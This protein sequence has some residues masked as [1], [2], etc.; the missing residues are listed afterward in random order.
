MFANGFAYP[1]LSD[2]TTLIFHIKRNIMKEPEVLVIGTKSFW[3]RWR[4]LSHIYSHSE[5]E[6]IDFDK[7]VIK[8]CLADGWTLEPWKGSK[9]EV[10]GEYKP[11]LM[12]KEWWGEGGFNSVWF[13]SNYKS[14]IDF[15]NYVPELM[16]DENIFCYFIGAWVYD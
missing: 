5:Q 11:I 16:R 7:K 8:A 13:T 15:Y 3:L 4:Y 14:P 1:K 12:I 10:E 6:I 9:P 2:L